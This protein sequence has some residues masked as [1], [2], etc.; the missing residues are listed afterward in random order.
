MK[1]LTIILLLAL[2]SCTTTNDVFYSQKMNVEIYQNF[3][4]LLF[5]D[6][7]IVNSEHNFIVFTKNMKTY[8][9]LE[10]HNIVSQ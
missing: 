7:Y 8:S 2:S 10:N 4:T 1:K 9:F 5:T 6:V 3:D